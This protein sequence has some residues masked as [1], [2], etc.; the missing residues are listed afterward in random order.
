M[1]N[2]IIFSLMLLLSCILSA[3]EKNDL[4]ILKNGSIIRGKIIETNAENVKILSADNLLVFSL[5]E[6]EKQ[7]FEITDKEN[8]TSP[9]GRYFNLTTMGILIGSSANAKVA[10]VSVLMEHNFRLSDYFAI[11][12]VFGF[13][14]LNETVCPVALSLK[15]CL[16]TGSDNYFL[17]IT[18]GYSISTEN[19][20]GNYYTGEIDGD[21]GYLL[22]LELGYMSTISKYAGVYFA[23]GYRY[24]ELNYRMESWMYDNI[25][26]KMFFHRLS[27]RMGITLF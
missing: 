5:T 26:R 10:P 23:V 3:Q 27:F 24:N 21:G 6:I 7:D 14:M 25:D 4:L 20:S 8:N 2:V 16:P 13:E 17:G 11:G 12:G 15:A 1:K 19:I 18:G 22:N 9:N